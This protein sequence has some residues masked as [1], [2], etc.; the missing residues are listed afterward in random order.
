MKC[1]L[2][3][4]KDDIQSLPSRCT[5]FQSIPLEQVLS[6]HHTKKSCGHGL[7]TSIRRQLWQDQSTELSRHR[8]QTQR[9]RGCDWKGGTETLGLPVAPS[10]LL[11]PKLKLLSSL[12]EG[13]CSVGICDGSQIH[14]IKNLSFGV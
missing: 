11:S 5:R 8:P 14:K 6:A 13:I 2:L 4:K 12:K 3:K 10:T 7:R 9:S 1:L